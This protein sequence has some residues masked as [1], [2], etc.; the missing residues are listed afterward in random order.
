MKK[1]R[2]HAGR[3]RKNDLVTLHSTIV[4]QLQNGYEFA[5]FIFLPYFDENRRL[6][7][8]EKITHCNFLALC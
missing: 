3:D 7:I 6:D 5:I 8:Y 1:S 2:N 4:F